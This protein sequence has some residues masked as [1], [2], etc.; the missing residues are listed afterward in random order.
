[1]KFVIQR[2][3]VLKGIILPAVRPQGRVTAGQIQRKGRVPEG[4]ARAA[5]PAPDPWSST[6]GRLGREERQMQPQIR[7]PATHLL[8]FSEDSSS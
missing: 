3:I 5:N 2:K 8:S 7:I 4:G 1:M 6:P